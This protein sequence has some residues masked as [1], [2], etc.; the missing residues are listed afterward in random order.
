ML[1]LG[2][3]QPRIITMPAL[4]RVF[5]AFCLLIFIAGCSQSTQNL[6]LSPTPPE[7]GPAMGSGVAVGLQIVDARSHSDLGVLEN[8]D[9]SIVRLTAA[10]DVA[11][12]LQLV[13]AEALRGYDFSPALWTSSTTPRVEIRIEQLDHE[14]TAGVPYQLETV[15]ALKGTAW[16]G[17]DRY[18][19][20]ARSNL[21]NQR[22]LPPSDKTNAEIIETAITRA[23]RQLL[24]E[25]F[26][27]FIQS[28][29]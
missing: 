17:D 8:P 24:D 6:R 23:L 2:N 9:G 28:R 21:S 16:A 15:V 26:A 3:H 10:Q 27:R 5:S 22:A 14:V 20:S 1:I 29:R 19:G 11:Y 18:T 7:T 4:I 13:A 12:A 25:D